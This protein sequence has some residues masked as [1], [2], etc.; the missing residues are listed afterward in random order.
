MILQA[1]SQARRDLPSGRSDGDAVTVTPLNL[2]VSL[3]FK[4]NCTDAPTL[5]SQIIIIVTATRLAAT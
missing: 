1:E 2:T 3:N 5:H 4:L